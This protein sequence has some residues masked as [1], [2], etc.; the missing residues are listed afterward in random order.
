LEPEGIHFAAHLK[1]VISTLRTAFPNLRFDAHELVCEG[2]TVA[3]RST[4]S[5][6]APA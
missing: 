1:N 2:A 3:C 4:I 5:V 6:S